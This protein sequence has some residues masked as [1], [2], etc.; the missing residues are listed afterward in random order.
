MNISTLAPV[1]CAN[2]CESGDGHI[3][4]SSPADQ[5]CMGESRS[6]LVSSDDY[7]TPRALTVYAT[8]KPGRPVLVNV[9]HNEEY[10]ADLTLSEVQQLRD[11]LDSVLSAHAA[12]LLV[13]A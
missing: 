8:Q 6:V 7:G 3:H 2:W 13:A 4:E 9:S 10:G 1:V 11:A 12:L 5:V